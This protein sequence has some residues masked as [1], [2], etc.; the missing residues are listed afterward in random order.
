MGDL[1]DPNER[2]ESPTTTFK[3]PNKGISLERMAFLPPAGLVKYCCVFLQQFLWCVP[4]M[5]HLYCMYL[6]LDEKY[7]RAMFQSGAQEE[8]TSTQVVESN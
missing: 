2:D 8:L 6:E 4:L 3:T 5:C 7:H 1:R